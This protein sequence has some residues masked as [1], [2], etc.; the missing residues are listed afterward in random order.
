MWTW[1]MRMAGMESM[2]P[3]INMFGPGLQLKPIS[4]FM[5]MSKA[6]HLHCRH[7]HQNPLS[8]SSPSTSSSSSSEFHVSSSSFEIRRPR[9]LARAFSGCRNRW[10]NRS[11]TTTVTSARLHWFSSQ[12]RRWRRAFRLGS[13]RREGRRSCPL[14]WD[15]FV[16]RRRVSRQSGA[17]LF[18]VICL[19]A[20]EIGGEVSLGLWDG[21]WE[22]VRDYDGFL[23]DEAQDP[24]P[25]WLG[26]INGQRGGGGEGEP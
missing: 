18:A 3:S 22:T 8:L 26:V 16:M 1:A 6:S 21:Q 23:G 5:G 2:R 4:I 9:A 24:H 7:H 10:L 12:I 11:W 13:K 14:A 20:I 25:D 19:V 17:S 15:D